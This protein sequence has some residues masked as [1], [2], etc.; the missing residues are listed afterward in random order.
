MKL[1]EKI[2]GKLPKEKIEED[3]GSGSNIQVNFGDVIAS[4]NIH[5]NVSKVHGPE[6]G[7]VNVDDVEKQAKIAQLLKQ[8]AD[9]FMRAAAEKL[10]AIQ[11]L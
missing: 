2:L 8:D 5:Y 11:G 9:I 3:M 4:V 1:A 10:K 6:M 7:V